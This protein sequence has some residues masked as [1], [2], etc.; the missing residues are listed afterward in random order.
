MRAYDRHLLVLD[1]PDGALG[2]HAME[3]VDLG[4]DVVYAQDI[5]EAHLLSRQDEARACA[6]LFACP[7]DPETAGQIIQRLSGSLDGPMDAIAPIGPRPEPETLDVLRAAGVR[8]GLF[9]PLAVREL[10]FVATAVLRA[11]N[12]ADPRKSDRF[13]TALR[14]RVRLDANLKD[15]RVHDLS[16]GGAWLEEPFPFPTGSQITLE[17]G[18]E[19]TR[20]SAT[21]VVV[22]RR[23]EADP[24][25][26]DAPAGMGVQFVEV[27]DE[28]QD[29]LR[30]FVTSC[31]E[32]Y[33][34]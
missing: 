7:A 15:V 16:L 3:L 4:V 33:Q 12:P 8:V 32:R 29:R 28:S 34:I 25:R 24:S 17:I 27:D 6:A 31:A 1:A 23:A 21:A 20:F 19:G 5:D 9:D 30:V 13:P 10:R 26:P 2:R 22:N 11:G 14:A 18:L